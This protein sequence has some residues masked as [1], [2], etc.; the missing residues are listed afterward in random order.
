MITPLNILIVDDH[1]MMVDAYVNIINLSID[2]YQ[3]N[4]IKANDCESAYKLMEQNFNTK[5]TIEIAL[6]DVSLPLYEEEKIFC[7][8]DLAK[9]IR[10]KFPTCK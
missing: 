4:F 5:Q 2:D 9:I 1:P 10:S 8:G 7:G 3:F 6:L